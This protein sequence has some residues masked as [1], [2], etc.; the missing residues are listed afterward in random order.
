MRRCKTK[1]GMIKRGKR[2]TE[3][4]AGERMGDRQ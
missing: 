3:V 1:R 2:G 4:T